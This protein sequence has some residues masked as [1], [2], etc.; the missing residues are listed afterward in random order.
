MSEYLLLGNETFSKIILFNRMPDEEGLPFPLNQSPEIKYLVASSLLLILIVGTI[1]RCKVVQY[2]LVAD[3][4]K[5]PI[6]F[7]FWLDQ[8]KWIFSGLNIVFAAMATVLPDPVSSIVGYELCNWFDLLGSA[9]LIS[10]SVWSC[11]MALFRSP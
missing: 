11:N 8:S 10:S 2:L 3:N 1:I 7:F 5:N 6:N 4:R 9:Y